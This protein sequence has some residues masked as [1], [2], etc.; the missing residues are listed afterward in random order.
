MSFA[1]GKTTVVSPNVIE[2]NGMTDTHWMPTSAVRD[3]DFVPKGARALPAIMESSQL[4]QYSPDSG[5]TWT[6]FAGPFTLRRELAR[7]V[8]PPAVAGATMPLLFTT[9]K[10][11]IHS[12]TEPYKP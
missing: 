4:Y 5:T 1:P 10:V 12:V 7:E 6:T 3:T 8:G 9:N 2:F 11:G